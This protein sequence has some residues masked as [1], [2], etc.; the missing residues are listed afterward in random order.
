MITFTSFQLD[1][2]SEIWHDFLYDDDGLNDDVFMDISYDWRR[3]PHGVTLEIWIDVFA[4]QCGDR[5]LV[6]KV[7]SFYDLSVGERMQVIPVL[8]D[9]L[10][11]L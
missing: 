10:G 1:E 8:R 2:I 3:I 6:S 5:I 11:G 4:D 7:R 9:S